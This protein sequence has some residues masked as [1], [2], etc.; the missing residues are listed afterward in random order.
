MSL[1]PRNFQILLD[2]ELDEKSRHALAADRSTGRD[3]G[4]T[5][6]VEDCPITDL[7]PSRS[8][9]RTTLHG[10]L[11]RGHPG[12]GGVPIAC[13]VSVTVREVVYYAEIIPEGQDVAEHFTHV[14]FGRSGKLYLAHRMARR[15]S[16]DQIVAVRLLPGSVTDMLGVPLPDEVARFGFDQAQ[17]VI[18]GQRGFAGRRLRVGEIAVAAFQA[19]A[20]VDNARCFLAELEVERQLHLEAD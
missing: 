13:E 14:C 10:T 18:V 16:F 3:D 7:D 19:T 15:P 8:Q 9:P 4:H 17:Q 11:F 6:A 20:S 5:L 1:P 12:R 2:A